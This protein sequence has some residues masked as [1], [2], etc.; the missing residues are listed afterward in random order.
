LSKMNY[1]TPTHPKEKKRR[2]TIVKDNNENAL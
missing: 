1:R 2:I